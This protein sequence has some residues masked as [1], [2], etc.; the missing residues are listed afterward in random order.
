MNATDLQRL[1]GHLR[2]HGLRVVALEAELRLHA[3]H[4]QHGFLT[5]EIVAEGGR[6][7]TSLFYGIGE[8]GREED[9]ADR[10]A[11]ARRFESH[12][13]GGVVTGLKEKRRQRSG[14]RA[15]RTWLGHTQSCPTCRV[16]VS[17]PTAVH[18]G[19]VWREVR[20]G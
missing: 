1:V 11:P 5:E 20:S 6:Y 4:P 19:R 3:T 13:S 16:G 8:R 12:H 17:C 18:L 2:N 10:I 14:E 9:C 7:V 15:Y